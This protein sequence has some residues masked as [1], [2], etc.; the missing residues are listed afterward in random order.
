MEKLMTVFFVFTSLNTCETVP[1]KL[2][3]VHMLFFSYFH[4]LYRIA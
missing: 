3:H 1:E 4:K 2:G